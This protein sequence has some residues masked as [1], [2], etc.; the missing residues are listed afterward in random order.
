MQIALPCPTECCESEL[1]FVSAGYRGAHLWT[2]CPRCGTGF[3]LH[4]GALR[5]VAL[6]PRAASP[7]RSAGAGFLAQT[8]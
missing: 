4:G 7:S 6:S 2:R 3:G 5:A 8:A 1:V